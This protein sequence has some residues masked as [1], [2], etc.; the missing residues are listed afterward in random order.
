MSE[1]TDVL[2]I[3]DAVSYVTTKQM[4]TILMQMKKSI[5]MIKGKSTGTGFFCRINYENKDIPCLITSYQVLDDEYIK[6]NKKIEINLNDNE[7][8][9]DIILSQEDIIYTNKKDEY[10][11]IIIKL[12]EEKEYMKNINYL[13]FDDNLFGDS[14]KGY[15]SI[16][17]LHYP[18]TKNAAVSYGNGLVND[19]NKYDIQHKYY[20]LPGSSG[21]PILNLSNNKVIGI[22]KG[23]IQKKDGT[24]YN[25]GTFLKEPLEEIKNNKINNQINNNNLYN[26]FNI[27]LKEP[28]HNDGRL[29]SG[30]MDGSIIIY[31]KETYKPDLIIKEHKYDVR[32][33]IQLSSGILASCSFDNT[34]KLFK[35]KGNEFEVLQ[36][37]NYHTGWVFK[38][39]EL[40]N[41]TLVSCSRDC[42]IIFYIKDN[43]SNINKWNMF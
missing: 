31:N 25:I 37:L 3:S 34:I 11:L 26:D 32:Y 39:I 9:E 28:I 40:K 33:I 12:K 19:M 7:I 5:C 36:I 4:E 20:T 35:I 23:C 13:E 2:V 38:I 10:D 21:G 41:K 22:H 14:L 15:D 8:N 27:E 43:L 6:E 42:S 1:R 18:N 17:I 30:S 29:V 24:K 16:Y